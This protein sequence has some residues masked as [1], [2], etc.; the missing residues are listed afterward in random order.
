[1]FARDSAGK[2]EMLVQ[3]YFPFVIFQ[4]PFLAIP[5]S[6]ALRR[7]RRALLQ[8]GLFVGA[9]LFSEIWLLPHY[10]APATGLF[11]LLAIDGLRFLRLWSFRG[12]AV[13]RLLV[14]LS[15]IMSAVLLLQYCL[16]LGRTESDGWNIE[17]ARI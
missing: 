10:A 4:I 8:A 13:G 16:Q 5:W 9:L 6:L 15:L 11:I 14:R 17:R 7:S 2:M 3:R 12:R 1:G